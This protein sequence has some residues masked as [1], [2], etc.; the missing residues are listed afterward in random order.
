MRLS[1]VVSGI[2]AFVLA[3]ALCL[4]AARFAV[5]AIEDGSEIAV[6]RTLD[7]NDLT[8]AE[9]HADGLQVVLSGL[10]PTEA[11]RFQAVTAAGSEVDA[12]RIL[13]EMEVEATAAIAPPRF[14]AE[15]LRN[16]SGVSI[17]GL[18]PRETDREALIALIK[19][20]SGEDRV[21]DLL[22]A[23]DYPV[24]EGWDDALGFAVTALAK[25]PRSKI[26]VDAGQIEVTAISDSAEAKQALEREL[27]RAVPPGLNLTLK[28]SAP[29]PVITPFTLR[30]L[31][32]EGQGRFD[33][34]SAD[35]EATAERILNVARDATGLSGPET[36][37]VGM[38][39][40]T[41]YWG[42]AADQAIR[43]LAALGDGSVTFADAD[44]T[45]VAAVG[46]DQS[47]FD[48]IVGELEVDLPDVFALHAILPQPEEGGDVGPPEFVAT[49]SPEGQVQLRGRLSDD[50]LRRM[51]DSFAK[52]AFGSE[53]VYTAARVV[54]N[55]PEN[56]PARVLA[57]LEALT[58]LT[59]GSV[60]VSPDNLALSGVTKLENARADLSGLLSNRLGEGALYSLDITY[61]APPPPEKIRPSPEECEA[62]LQAVQT[63]A[64]I[65]FEPGSATIAEESL[66]V[67][68]R[69]AD[70][71]KECGDIRLEIQGHTDSQG[72]ESM[73]LELS[74]A[75]ADSVLAELQARRVLTASYEARG[76][77]ESE[78]I[79]DN[80]SEEGREANRRIEF[81]L[82][83]PE[84]TEET[85]TT[86]E[87]TAAETAATAEETEATEQQEEA[88]GE[89]SDEQN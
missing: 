40:P 23:A 36:C 72:R 80:G 8:W 49:R 81:H 44:I 65:A 12:T 77:G 22:E 28:I 60:I 15:I 57:G 6:R 86:L 46:T 51:A 45:L 56:W 62:Q 10:A 83:Q 5:M 19:D 82:I 20:R 3:A 53:N 2:V 47:Q 42:A 32:E 59:N 85:E 84:V 73:N 74:Q 54:D 41:P 34:C 16:E 1:S 25:L 78:P 75:R 76:Y 13:D 39:V 63:G 50:S 4:V 68:N 61:R 9:V 87:E 30:F 33:A 7:N 58:Y 48:R 71:L 37:T 29:R 21:A 14:S 11:L 18:V 52:A 70:I 43:A 88:E 31:V 69:I 66:G 89:T 55:M 38:G 26:S 79:A 35:T 27:E 24:P 17:I 64:K 67:M